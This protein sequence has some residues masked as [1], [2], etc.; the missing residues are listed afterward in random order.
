MA[1]DFLVSADV[2]HTVTF[3][4]GESEMFY[5]QRHL[6]Y[7]A[8]GVEIGGQKVTWLMDDPIPSCNPSSN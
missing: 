3:D 7:A 8:S 4:N 1:E 5:P 6:V 2:A